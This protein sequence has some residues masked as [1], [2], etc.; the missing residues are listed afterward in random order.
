MG[1]RSRYLEISLKFH[2]FDIR[3][4]EE[5]FARV[6]STA[7]VEGL[8][9]SGEP[10]REVHEIVCWLEKIENDWFFDQIEVVTV[11]EK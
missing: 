8:F 3:F 1:V 5:G 4:P 6:T 10:F 7:F 11:L 2:D 9:F